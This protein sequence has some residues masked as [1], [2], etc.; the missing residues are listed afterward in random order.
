ME[1]LLVILGIIL[2]VSSQNKKNKKNTQKMHKVTAE[3]AAARVNEPKH[4]EE[5]LSKLHAELEKRKRELQMHPETFTEAKPAL[6]EG[7]SLFANTS[8]DRMESLEGECICDPELEHERESVSEPESVYTGEI[9]KERLVDYS[10]RGILQGVI[11][12]E[13]LTRPSKRT[14]RR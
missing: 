1:G 8:F 12:S 2:W 3:K 13:I 10:P 14:M 11:M 9:G 7:R 6:D 4:R 5:R